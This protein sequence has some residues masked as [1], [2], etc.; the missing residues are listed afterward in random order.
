MDWRG[1]CFVW[2]AIHLLFALPVNRFLLPRMTRATAA[3]VAAAALLG[4]AQVGARLF[5]FGIVQRL[6]IQHLHTARV[7]TALNPLASAI[8]IALGG[9]APPTAAFALL[10]G[11]GDGLI[12]IAKGALPLALVE[13]QGYGARLGTLAIAQRI[14]QAAA[15]LSF[16]LV[17]ETGDARVATAL[18]AA[19]SLVALAASLVVSTA[20]NGIVESGTR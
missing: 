3:G 20:T 8:L 10:Y 9:S 16:A 12:T 15:P 6:R 7:A 13:A 11:A 1:A 17:I 19:V 18:S 2:A 14:T 4:R 5:E